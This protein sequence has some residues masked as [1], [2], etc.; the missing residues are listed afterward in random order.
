MLLPLQ[1]VNAMAI[2]NPGCRFACPGLCAVAPSGRV[3]CRLHLN[4]SSKLDCIRFAY[5]CMG[6]KKEVLR[7]KIALLTK[8]VA[9]LI[10]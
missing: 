1:G 2:R 6:N 10:F 4:N 8:K 9:K 7:V 3:H 5:I